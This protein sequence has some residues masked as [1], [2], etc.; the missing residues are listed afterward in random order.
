MVNLNAEEKE[1][2]KLFEEACRLQDVARKSIDHTGLTR[3]GAL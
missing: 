3:D 2:H 1:V